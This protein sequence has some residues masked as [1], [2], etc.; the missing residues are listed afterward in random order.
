MTIFVSSQSFLLRKHDDDVLYTLY[1]WWC[2]MIN[3]LYVKE[4]EST[5]DCLVNK[6]ELFYW[7]SHWVCVSE[8]RMYL[9]SFN[10]ILFFCVWLNSNRNFSFS[11]L[12]WNELLQLINQIQ[13]QPDPKQ[14]FMKDAEDGSS[15]G[16]PGQ[17]RSPPPPL[18]GIMS[19][20]GR[21][22]HGSWPVCHVMN[23]YSFHLQMITS[24]LLLFLSESPM[25]RLILA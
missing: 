2:H 14:V 22:R 1:L 9:N 11:L 3:G 15:A 8:M 10:W 23:N 13:L 19:A 5:S 21:G 17:C 25:F 16:K 20:D 7:S 4:T 24:P 18:S 12:K 6:A